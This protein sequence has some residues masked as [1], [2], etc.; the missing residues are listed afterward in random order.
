LTF[1]PTP[2]MMALAAF[3]YRRQLARAS[4]GGTPPDDGAAGAW[5]S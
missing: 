5:I 1:D 3:L 4:G 2:L